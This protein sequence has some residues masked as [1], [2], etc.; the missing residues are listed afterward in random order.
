[1][2]GF[3]ED[4]KA[5]FAKHAIKNV[6]T[7]YDRDE[8]GDTAAERLREELGAMGIGSHRVLFPK[9]MDAN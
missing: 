8:A 4:H 7:A 9:G 5:A 3:T 1:V 6:L 2:S